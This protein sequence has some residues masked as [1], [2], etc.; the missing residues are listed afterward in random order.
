MLSSKLDHWPHARKRA[1]KECTKVAAGLDGLHV[2]N[3]QIKSR[4]DEPGGL[5]WHSNRQGG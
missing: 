3:A 4:R 2:L 5:V 1:P